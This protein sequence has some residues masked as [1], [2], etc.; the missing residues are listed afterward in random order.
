MKTMILYYSWSGTTAQA[1]NLIQKATDG[2]MTELKV[3]A[4]TF[5]DDMYKTSDIA[6]QQR[7]SGNLPELINKIPDLNE[8][9]LVLVGGPVWSGLV[10]T[11]IQVLLKELSEF[12]G[13]VIPFYTSAGSDQNYETDF[14]QLGKELKVKKGLRMASFD[15][16]NEQETI[17][18]LKDWFNGSNK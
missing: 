18:K 12:K 7:T 16:N 6:T 1:A 2:D 9:D 15:L 14:K 11:P 17:F 4:G 3:V 13:T 8:Y 5:P 10:S